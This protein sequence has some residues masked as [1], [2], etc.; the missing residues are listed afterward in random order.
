[1]RWPDLYE[2]DFKLGQTLFGGGA[3]DPRK[4]QLQDGGYMRGY[5][6][7]RLGG[8]DGRQAPQA[9]NTQIAMGPQDQW[10]QRE[11]ALADS[12]GRVASG[13]EKGAGEMAVGRQF[14]QG[15]AAQMAQSRMA[16]GGNAGIAARAAARSAGDMTVNAAGQSSQAALQ[17]QGVA[18][19][20]LAGVLNQ[21]RGA[22]IGL[23]TNQAGMNQQT[24]LANMHAKLQMMGM[25]DQAAL[26]YLAQMNQMSIAEMQARLAQEQTNAQDTGLFGDLLQA[27]G[28]LGAAYLGRPGGG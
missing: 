5:I 17:D 20:L 21:G 13:A 27:G 3:T 11:M 23:A 19:Q 1:M 24:S 28:G 12:L 18:R 4:A 22:D 26:A 10:R 2:G 25:N 15:L 16:R 6:K 14:Q 7:Q 8:L 9:G